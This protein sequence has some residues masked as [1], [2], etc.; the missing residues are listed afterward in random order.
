MRILL[1]EDE[2]D[3]REKI[4]SELERIVGDAVDIV[5]RESLRGGLKAILTIEDIDL[6]LLDMSMPSFDVTDDIGG[7]HPES[8]AGFE[9]MAQMKLRDVNI[10]VLVV[11]QY[12]TFEKGSFSLEEL[13]SKM[14]DEF[15]SFYRGT[16]YYNSSLEEWKKQL[17]EYIKEIKG[18]LN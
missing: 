10:P 12:K 8:F 2:Y 18:A 14:S 1:I 15:G 3:K 9:I 6:I 13:I 5:E 4:K 17:L 7:E 16:I 11:T